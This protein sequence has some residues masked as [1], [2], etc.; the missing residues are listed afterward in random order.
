[1]NRNTKVLRLW[2]GILWIGVVGGFLAI[3]AVLFLNKGRPEEKNNLVPEIRVALN[4]VTLDEINSG[5]KRVPYSGNEMILI[6]GDTRYY[7]DN[8]EIRGRGNASWLMEKKSYR[9]KLTEKTD[10]LGLGK[11]KK[12]AMISNNADN[13]LMR[14]D[15]GY[16][17]AGLLYDNYPIRGEFARFVVDGEN[18]GLYYMSKMVFV[19]KDS[20]DL[21]DP[22]G[23]LVEVD[24]VYYKTGGEYRVSKNM[25]DYI[26]VED[27]VTEDNIDEALDSFMKDYDELERVIKLGDY[28]LVAK[29]ADVESWAKYFLLSEFSSN[30]DA[31]VTSWYLYKDGEGDKIHAGVGWDFDG[32]FG[33][34]N[35]WQRDDDLYSPVRLMARMKSL[36][37]KW[38]EYEGDT[39]RC[40]L[41]DGSLISPAMCYLFEMP[42]FRQLLAKVY[43]E[44]LMT[45]RE[46]ILS[47]I[48]KRADY[49]RDAAIENNELWNKGSFDEEVEYL[50][51][52]VG[53]RFDYFD[54]IFG[55][56][57]L[58]PEES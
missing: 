54:D 26:S 21:R 23:I 18:L 38:D 37:S 32:A 55:R 33:N 34:E 25:S 53:K 42:D 14:N 1:M 6:D 29:K 41:L 20:I 48:Q 22:L 16:Y 56:I 3:V 40:D 46:E 19:G 39:R 2:R 57:E 11:T 5:P 51:W 28:W 47:Y 4:G 45:K 35:W 15:L 12:W 58:L 30:P 9:I 36:V 49:I 31:Y 44:K 43:R 24:D 52:W 10:L 17:V 27:A 7:F 8:M 50:T 13:S